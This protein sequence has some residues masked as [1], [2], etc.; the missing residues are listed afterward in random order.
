MTGA[1]FAN[2]LATASIGLIQVWFGST[3]FSEW[4]WRIPFLLSAVLVGLGL[5]MRRSLIE[6][7]A[8]EALRKQ[9]SVA[10]N[11]LSESLRQ[12]KAPM[13][14]TLLLKAAENVVLYLFTTFFLVLVT[15]HLGLSRAWGLTA[16]FWGSAIEI[17]IILLAAHASDVVGR[18]PV[19]AIGLLG[20]LGAA[21]ALFSL[22]PNTAYQTLMAMTVLALTCHGIALGGMSAW[23][24]ELFPA[25]VR[26]SA[27]STSYQVASVIGGSVAP[28]VGTFLLD[29]TGTPMAVAMYAAAMIAPA[30]LVCLICA[31]TKGALLDATEHEPQELD[32]NQGRQLTS[33]VSA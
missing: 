11:P 26:F 17:P 9:Q 1:A 19:T 29:R 18:R 23:F 5:W 22:Q 14:Q 13:I 15:Q 33:S 27:L 30:L 4:A 3:A 10:R 6:P 20:A 7:P 2:L 31:E 16:L 21:V 12:W 25:R 24:T 8:F 28:L 32:S